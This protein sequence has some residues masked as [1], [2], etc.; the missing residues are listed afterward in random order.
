MG[1]ARAG[2]PVNKPPH[3]TTGSVECI[4][5]IQSALGDEYLSYCQGNVIKYVWR[6]KHKNGHQDLAK[7][8]WYLNEM[9]RILGGE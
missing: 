1:F 3:Y 7:A 8:Q 6:Y 2:D 4:E 5:A 9:L